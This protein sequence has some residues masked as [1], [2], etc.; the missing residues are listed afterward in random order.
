MPCRGGGMNRRPQRSGS[1]LPGPLDR[2]EAHV[3]RQRAFTLIEPFDKLGV[4]HAFTLIELLVVI[5]IISVLAALLLPAVKDA[6]DSAQRVACV[7]RLRQWGLA[8]HSYSNENEDR[9][10]AS[11]GATVFPVWFDYSAWGQYVGMDPATDT[12]DSMIRWGQQDPVARAMRNCPV[13]PWGER[14]YRT[15]VI[16]YIANYAVLGA[17]AWQTKDMESFDRPGSWIVLSDLLFDESKYGFSGAHYFVRMGRHHADGTNLLFLDGH[18]EWSRT[19]D[20][21]PTWVELGRRP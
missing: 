7:A 9:L 19:D 21:T 1:T 14:R 10:P 3:A 11:Y 2:L 4:R 18:L 13:Y 12:V 6:R 16:G 15:W 17:A 8:M 5:A 20:I